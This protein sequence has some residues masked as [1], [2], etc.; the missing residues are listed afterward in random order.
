ME[1]GTSQ[2]SKPLSSNLLSCHDVLALLSSIFSLTRRQMA[3]YSHI[4]DEHFLSL[5]SAPARRRIQWLV[6]TAPSASSCPVTQML[7]SSSPASLPK[8]PDPLYGVQIV[9]TTRVLKAL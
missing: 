5:V 8:R 2:K 7:A 4:H 6:A 9:A 1:Q 3:I